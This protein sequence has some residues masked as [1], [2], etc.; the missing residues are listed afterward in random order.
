ME[1]A[2]GNMIPTCLAK[3]QPRLDD[4]NEIDSAKQLIK[5][6]LGNSTYH[7]RSLGDLDQ[8]ASSPRNAAARVDS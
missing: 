5:K 1:W 4:V 7:T 8:T 2:T 6:I 3:R